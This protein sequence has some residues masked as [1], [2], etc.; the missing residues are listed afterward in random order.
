MVST[1]VSADEGLGARGRCPVPEL[2]FR[3]LSPS[4]N[5]LATRWGRIT[6]SGR[7]LMVQIAEILSQRMDA[8][9]R[10]TLMN[11][12]VRDRRMEVDFDSVKVMF[13]ETDGEV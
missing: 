5:E 7:K 8:Q 12:G 11:G 6:P 1:G 4:F 9:V 13:S 3:K 2:D 10:F